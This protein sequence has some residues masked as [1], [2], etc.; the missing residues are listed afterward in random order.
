MQEERTPYYIREREDRINIFLFSF[1]I[2]GAVFAFLFWAAYITER[3][4]LEYILA[5]CEKNPYDRICELLP[6][7]K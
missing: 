6:E 3:E 4:R 1:A 5:V 7:R 2:I